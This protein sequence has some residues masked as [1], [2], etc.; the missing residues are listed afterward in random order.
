MAS[1]NVPIDI[2]RLMKHIISK[3]IQLVYNKNIM[4]IKNTGCKYFKDSVHWEFSI[5]KSKFYI[6]INELFEM[7][8]GRRQNLMLINVIDAWKNDYYSYHIQ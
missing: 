5:G 3:E 6:T 2:K 4:K 1:S 7:V 8:N